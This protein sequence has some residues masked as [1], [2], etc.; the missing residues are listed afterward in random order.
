MEDKQK[1][2]KLIEASIPD[3]STNI[4]PIAYRCK[5]ILDV[6]FSPWS[7]TVLKTLLMN[8]DSDSIT[9][10]DRKLIKH[11]CTFKSL[12]C[13]IFTE[14]ELF[15]KE[16]PCLISLRVNKLCEDKCEDMALNLVTS[17][18]RCFVFLLL[19]QPQ[20]E[21]VEATKAAD[22]QNNVLFDYYLALLVKYKKLDQF[23]EEMDKLTLDFKLK[24]VQRMPNTQASTKELT[25]HFKKAQMMVASA[26]VRKILSDPDPTNL[27]LTKSQFVFKATADETVE[28]QKSDLPPSDMF[29][30][31]VLTEWMKL[32]MAENES[33]FEKLLNKLMN[34]A[35]FPK[36]L[37]MCSKALKE[38]VSRV[39]GVFRMK[40]EISLFVLVS[41]TLRS[42]LH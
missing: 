31:K 10:K 20:H 9:I 42:A 15:T 30:V 26:L 36:H 40:A 28:Q 33:K 29:Y 22:F 1:L 7:D 3:L 37:Y 34:G 5:Y 4:T 32:N 39:D 2:Y 21:L 25:K 12:D 35:I 38:M 16:R 8:P 24:T 13:R 14:I 27:N 19:E 23:Q 18:W 17:Y 41:N 11:L 6:M